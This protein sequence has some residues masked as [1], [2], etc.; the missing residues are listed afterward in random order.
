MEVQQEEDISEGRARGLGAR[1]LHAEFELQGH[2]NVKP[3]CR[4]NP[5]LRA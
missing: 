3:N 2:E 5:L 1:N 4:L